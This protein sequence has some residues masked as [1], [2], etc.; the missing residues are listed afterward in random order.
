MAWAQGLAHQS[1]STSEMLY[2]T[3]AYDWLLFRHRLADRMSKHEEVMYGG[4]H[5]LSFAAVDDR[6][7]FSIGPA[8][9]AALRRERLL[10]LNALF[11]RDWWQLVDAPH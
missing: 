9:S 7:C 11:M 4:F 10:E 6:L 5:F 3:I 2:F 1:L 8:F